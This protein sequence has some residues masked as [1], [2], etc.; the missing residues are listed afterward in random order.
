MDIQEFLKRFRLNQ[1]TNFFKKV[2]KVSLRWVAIVVSLL[3]V[4]SYILA[5]SGIGAY[6]KRLDSTML[7]LNVVNEVKEIKIKFDEIDNFIS[8]VRAESFPVGSMLKKISNIATKDMFFQ[9]LSL[10]TVSKTGSVRGFVKVKNENPNTILT[11]FVR[12]QEKSKYFSG[13]NIVSVNS[14]EEYG[15][16]IADFTINFKLP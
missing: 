6:Q 10:D 2:E 8:G 5:K 13:A 11:N 9:D 16:N 4:M 7:H 3:L 15:F 14:K 12:Q 1:M